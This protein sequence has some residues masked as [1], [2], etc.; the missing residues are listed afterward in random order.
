MAGSG[1]TITGAGGGGAGISGNVNGNWGDDNCA[2]TRILSQ[3]PG[4]GSTDPTITFNSPS[5]LSQLSTIE[6]KSISTDIMVSTCARSSASRVPS[7][8][9]A[10]STI[11]SS[12]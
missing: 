9:S 12:L 4:G 5:L 6:R 11:W 2:A 1:S 8:Y 10:A 7:T 3:R